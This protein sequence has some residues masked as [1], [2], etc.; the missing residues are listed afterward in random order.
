MTKPTPNPQT[1]PTRTPR[2][3]TE[4]PQKNCPNKPKLRKSVPRMTGT[5]VA[6]ASKPPPTTPQATPRAVRCIGAKAR[7]NGLGTESLSGLGNS[8]SADAVSL[9]IGNRMVLRWGEGSNHHETNSLPTLIVKFR[10]PAQSGIARTAVRVRPTEQIPVFGVPY[11]RA[12]G[13]RLPYVRSR[14]ICLQ[15]TGSRVPPLFFAAPDRYAIVPLRP[16]TRRYCDTESPLDPVRLPPVAH[17]DR[18]LWR[19][20]APGTLLR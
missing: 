15:T 5:R 10:P 9:L 20:S 17:R 2:Q 14:S 3:E 16:I 1:S 12:R 13:N 19:A 11:L 4:Y 7:N 6:T 18:G 8:P